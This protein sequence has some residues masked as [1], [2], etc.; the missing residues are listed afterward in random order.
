MF[1]YLIGVI[2]YDTEL[3]YRIS[4]FT[5]GKQGFKYC[6]EIK[7]TKSKGKFTSKLTSEVDK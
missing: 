2:T 7:F 3:Y 5:V 1:C 6:Y 4:C